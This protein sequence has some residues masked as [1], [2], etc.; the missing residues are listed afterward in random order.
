MHRGGRKVSYFTKQLL[1]LE[2][3]CLPNCN[4]FCKLSERRAAGYRAH[5]AFGQKANLFNAISRKSKRKLQNI[6]ARWVLDLRESVGGRDSTC[7]A[8]MLEVI[9]DLGRIHPEHL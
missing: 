5:A 9:E 1:S 8:R 7:I 3:P 2:F 4:A 6:A